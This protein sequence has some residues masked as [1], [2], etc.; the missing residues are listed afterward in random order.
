M[1]NIA[2]AAYRAYQEALKL[3][4][5][6]GTP[7]NLQALEAAAAESRRMNKLE[8]DSWTTPAQTPVSVPS[9][10]GNA[11]PVVSSPPPSS[12][13]PPAP[14]N[15]PTFI[16]MTTVTKNVKV[17]PSDIIQFD[18][19]SVGIAMISDLLYED[20]G[21]VELANISRTDLIDGQEVLYSPIKNLSNIRRE[22]NPNNVIATA[23]N[24][25]FFSRFAIDASVRGMHEPYFNANGDLVIE[26]D[27]ILGSEEVEVQ[28][29]STG[30]ID[31][32]GDV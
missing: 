32:I 5:I 22:F 13:P 8:Q 19:S 1:G 25:D 17:A 21:A 20:I 11:S 18:D 26:I 31:L 9:S 24:S 7:G 3:A 29:L 27:T 16:P 23:R 2:D 14:I 10:G 6:N 28:V 30:T 12:P 15:F 4:Q